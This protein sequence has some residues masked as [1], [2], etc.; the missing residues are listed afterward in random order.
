MTSLILPPE[1]AVVV[2][3]RNERGNVE[4]LLRRLDLALTNIR[5]EVLFVDDDSADGTADLVD[6]I[7][8][9]D[10]RV[11]LL[12]RIG[13]RGLSS[14]CIEGIL[15]TTAPYVAVIDGDLQHDETLLSSM[16][17][18]V[19]QQQLDI[20][21]GSRM[22]EGG[23]YGDMP[24]YRRVLSKI[25]TKAAKLVLKADL[26]DPMSG[27]FLVRRSSF[28]QLVPS[29]SGTG[30][31]ILLDIFASSPRGLRFA[32]LPYRFRERFAGE[33]KMDGQVIVEYGQLLL[34]KLLGR[35]LPVRFVLFGLVGG[36]GFLVHM[37]A[38]ALLF[39]TDLLNF[40]YSQA[41]ATMIAMT[42]NFGLNN[43]VTYRDRK[44][45]GWRLVKGLLS[46]Y[47]ICSLGAVANV[48]VAV[49]LYADGTYA[50]WWLAAVAGTLVGSVWNYVMATLFTWRARA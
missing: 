19:R 10:A 8:Q 9:R 50:V 6:E 3:T 14:A 24:L 16:L 2:P 23:S 17:H 22:T 30:F 5:W 41:L 40:E 47:V 48:G 33:S 34:D 49:W 15:A 35:W 4:E 44:L 32:E 31:K 25:A 29:L 26:T 21:V 39:R 18:A 12:R 28:T 46:F 27:F 42:W 37:A 36:L 1:L 43:I 13:R 7:G 38:L 45:A 11:R 20:A